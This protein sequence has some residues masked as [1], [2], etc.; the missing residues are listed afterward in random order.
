MRN[1]QII[2]IITTLGL[3][4]ALPVLAPSHF[5]YLVA[6]IGTTSI[7]VAGLAVVTGHAGQI[8]IAQA[9]F[10]ALGAYGT[11]QLANMAGVP[12]W[13]GLPAVSLATG[14]LGY[15]FG[16]L[17]LRVADHYLALA[18][19]ALC[20]IVQLLLVHLEDW[21]GGAVGLPVPPLEIGGHALTKPVELYAVIVPLAVLTAWFLH[22]LQ[23]SRTGR[24]FAALRMSEIGAAA[25]GIPVLQHKAL[26]F[27]ISA[28]LGA[29][30]GGLFALQTTYLD[31]AQFGILESVRLIAIAVIGGLLNPLGPAIGAAVFVMLPETMGALGRAMGLVFSLMLLIFIVLAPGGLA[32]LAGRIRLRLAQRRAGSLRP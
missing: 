26:A 31:P 1:H 29:L 22:A 17:S 25:V 5:V 16:L 13:V 8:S 20:A 30:G 23:S 14:L 12:H 7:M 9:S 3:L 21:T 27:S 4:A 2:A 28:F 15:L 32:G 24:A 18:T 10:A 6:L 11:A 19:M